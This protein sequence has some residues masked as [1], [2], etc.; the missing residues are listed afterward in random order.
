M[1]EVIH[2]IRARTVNKLRKDASALKKSLNIPHHEALDLTA[3]KSGFNNWEHLQKYA[4][5][6]SNSEDAFRNGFVIVMD[7]KDVHESK[8]KSHFFIED[9]YVLSI[10]YMDFLTQRGLK[11]D[12]ELDEDQR[13]FFEDLSIN[14]KFFRY[15]GQLPSYFHEAFKLSEQAF[16]FRADYVWLR[17][18]LYDDV[19]LINLDQ[20]L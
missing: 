11:S 17:G 14:K 12:L 15:T 2:V 5:L 4:A 19:G 6:T 13:Y 18:E 10:F 3:R 7:V 9:D 20:F 16:F 8:R 1:S